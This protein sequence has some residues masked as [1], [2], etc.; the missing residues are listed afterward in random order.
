MFPSYQDRQTFGCRITADTPRVQTTTTLGRHLLCS[1]IM[2]EQ[3]D[4]FGAEL[5][6]VYRGAVNTF[7]VVER[8]DGLISV[9]N[10]P[11]RYFMDYKEWSK[12]EKQ[13]MRLVQGRVLDIGCGAGR[14]GLHLQKKRFDVTGID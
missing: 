9:S 4:A 12:R 6:A 8:D 11:A 1:P 13:A 14:H 10:W 3:N 2:K 5:M 7:E